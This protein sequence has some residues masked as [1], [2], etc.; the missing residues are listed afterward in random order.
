MVLEIGRIC[1]ISNSHK[2]I[3]SHVFVLDAFLITEL[4]L[5]LFQ[6]AASHSMLSDQSSYARFFTCKLAI[7]S[8]CINWHSA[9]VCSYHILPSGLSFQAKG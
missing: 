9:V 6:A 2:F 7:L 8:N 5:Q 1:V 3:Y 4:R